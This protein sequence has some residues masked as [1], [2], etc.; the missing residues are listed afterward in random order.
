MR[1]ITKLDI[2]NIDDN[3]LYIDNSRGLFYR[4]TDKEI[5]E[6]RRYHRNRLIAKNR[7]RPKESQYKVYVYGEETLRKKARLHKTNK[8]RRITKRW[9]KR[10]AKALIIRG[11]LGVV[12]AAGIFGAYKG[13]SGLI[14]QKEEMGIESE[15][16]ETE[17]E[18]ESVEDMVAQVDEETEARDALIKKYCDIFQVDYDITHAL[19]QSLTD[20]FTSDDYY[21]GRIPGIVCKGVQVQ[22]QSE[23][24]L[25]ILAIRN[26]KQKPE[27]FNLNKETLYIN[28]GYVSSSDYFGQIKYYSDIFGLDECLIAAIVQSETGFDSNLF[29]T[30]NNPAG[31]RLNGEWWEFAN[32]EE[33]II[34]LCLEVEKY[35]RKINCSPL[36][37]NEAIIEAIGNIH[38]PKSD[39]NEFWVP[40]VRSNY[41]KYKNNYDEFF[42]RKDSNQMRIM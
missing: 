29:N 31:L 11:V 7:V 9:L 33:G 39:G 17:Y 20:N 28:N 30:I 24:E 5:I 4:L 3:G 25:I 1:D 14:G 40:N 16:D 41:Y 8:K 35:Y 27:S 19:L 38:A 12:L 34:E 21:E 26:I 36:D 42:V 22:A 37:V 6:I 2:K 15:A 13:V 32:K 23:E 18:T 10:N